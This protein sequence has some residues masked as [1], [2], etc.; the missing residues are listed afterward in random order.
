[1]RLIPDEDRD[2]IEKAIYLPMVIIVLNHDLQ[3]INTSPIKLKKPYTEWIKETIGT[4]QKELSNVKRYMKQNNIKV[5][6]VKTE[7]SF[8]QYL[9]IY[10]GYEDIHRYFNPRLKNR[11]EEL[12]EY[13]LYQRYNS[14]TTKNLHD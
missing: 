9:F 11:T 7:E 13:Y 8:T 1:M 12:L 3:I 14:T 5:E 4:V 6:K 2:I 10:K